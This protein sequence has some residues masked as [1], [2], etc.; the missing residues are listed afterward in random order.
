MVILVNLEGFK[1][2]LGV[3]VVYAIP[4]GYS[5]YFQHIEL[6]VNYGIA[7]IGVI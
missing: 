5:K 7:E 2:T 6:D 3:M 4:G 1:S